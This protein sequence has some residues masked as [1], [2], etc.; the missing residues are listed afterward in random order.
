M[1]TKLN[2]RHA[3][4]AIV[5]N[6]DS[7]DPGAEGE[8]LTMLTLTRDTIEIDFGEELIETDDVHLEEITQT[9]LDV[10]NPTA[11]VPN[12]LD[13]PMSVLEE[14]GIIGADGTYSL[15]DREFDAVR[16]IGYESVAAETPLASVDM[17]SAV[18]QWTDG[19]NWGTG[20]HVQGELVVHGND[21]PIINADGVVGE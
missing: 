4:V 5:D 18:I 20:E 6:Y 8:E 3:E 21:H 2:G 7:E 10:A 16:I 15:A 17:P 12:Y 9:E 19:P 13:P 14:A 1:T 11:T